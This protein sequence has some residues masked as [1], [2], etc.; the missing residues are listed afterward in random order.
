MISIRDAGEHDVGQITEIYRH[1]VLNGTASYEIDPPLH[2]EMAGRMSA[3]RQ[4][5]YPYIVA[6]DEGAVAGYA[7]AGPFR[8]RP[9]YRFMVE[10]SIYVAPDYKGKG[11]GSLLLDA[12]VGECEQRGYRQ[13][14]AVIGDGGS[15]TASVALHRKAGFVE[16][17]RIIGSGYKFNRWLD[18]ILM[19]KP[20]N[21]GASTM[22]DS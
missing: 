3:I 22:P 8:T 6:A 11:I 17:G 1:A 4:G 19:Q 20:I 10:D 15:N 7:Y 14:V 2:D 18:T 5:G 13:I 12:L 9:A 16:C 21:G